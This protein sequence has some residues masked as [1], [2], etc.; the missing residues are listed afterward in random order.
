MLVGTSGCTHWFG[1]SEINSLYIVCF[2]ATG[3]SIFMRW[4][5]DSCPSA[6]ECCF[7][8]LTP[9]PCGRRDASDS[10]IPKMVKFGCAGFPGILPLV[11]FVR[12]GGR[13]GGF[14]LLQP[15]VRQMGGS[16]VPFSQ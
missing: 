10:V 14:M 16:E 8:P 12:H 1:F 15:D 3:K 4:E 2:K 7:C 6:H 5:W 11:L 13:G 9:L